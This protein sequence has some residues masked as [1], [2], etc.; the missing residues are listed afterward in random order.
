M[1][2][3]SDSKRVLI[4]EDQ[5]LIAFAMQ[6]LMHRIDGAIAMTT[7]GCAGSA[8]RAL[9][10]REDW[11]RVFLAPDMPGAEGMS[12][13]RRLCDLDFAGRCTLVAQSANPAWIHEARASGLLGYILC[14]VPVER[15]ES[16]LRAVLEG[17][18]VFP[19][20]HMPPALIR[21]TP[22][23]QEVLALL[24]RGCSSKEIAARLKIS[25]G[26]VNNHVASLIRQFGVSNR[27]QAI[28]R[29]IEL[30]YLR[31]QSN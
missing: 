19:P 16:D 3:G 24:R 29:A 9:R 28:A 20:A 22:R 25:E 2:S 13:V 18:R 23:Q 15:F 10:Q 11:H 31:W 7:C 27:T 14:S 26:T 4:I 12:L 1:Q 30:G 17:R 8:L 21:L 5:P 6:R